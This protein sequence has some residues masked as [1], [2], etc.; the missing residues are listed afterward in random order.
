MIIAVAV[1][2]SAPA[3]LESAADLVYTI[4]HPNFQPIYLITDLDA[5]SV[6][7]RLLFQTGELNKPYVEMRANNTKYL[8]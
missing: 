2:S 7:A 6:D 1:V 5:W 4:Q 8:V 3:V